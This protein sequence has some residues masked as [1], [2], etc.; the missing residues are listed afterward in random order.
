MHEKNDV[1]CKVQFYHV[2]EVEVGNIKHF[3]RLLLGTAGSKPIFVVSQ[4]DTAD[5]LQVSAV[6]FDKLDRLHQFAPEL[7]VS[8]LRASDYKVMFC[9]R[10][11]M[12]HHIS[13]HPGLLILR[14]AG[15]I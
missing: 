15:Q 1:W 2:H 11:D 6:C 12:S 7:N 14:C 4:G 10:H 8:I 3:D 13:V 9:S 5:C